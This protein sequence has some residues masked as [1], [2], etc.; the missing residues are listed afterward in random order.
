MRKIKRINHNLAYGKKPQKSQKLN[1]FEMG[2]NANHIISHIKKKKLWL[3]GM[4]LIFLF[5]GTYIQ[6]AT[7]PNSI[8][9][10]TFQKSGKTNLHS[11]KTTNS[12]T[13]IPQPSITEERFPNQH[14][15]LYDPG[16]DKLEG[17][18]EWQK[19]ETEDVDDVGGALTG[20]N[21]SL[22]TEGDSDSYY[23][24]ADPLDPDWIVTENPDFPTF[25][26]NHSTDANGFNISHF[27]YETPDQTPSIHWDYN[28]SLP[29]NL[30][31]YKITDFSLNATVNGSVVGDGDGTNEGIDVAGDGIEQ[32]AT[33]DYARY[34]VLIS[35]IPKEKEYELAFYQTV[36]LGSDADGQTSNLE[37]TF[38]NVL[39]KESLILYLESVLNTD[40]QNFTISL[41]IRL[42]CEDS[43]H[44]DIDTWHYIR[45]NS[46]NMSISWERKINQLSSISWDQTGK[47]I[48]KTY[49][50]ELYPDSTVNIE[51]DNATLD[52]DY[53]IDT[54]WPTSSLNSELKYYIDNY[55]HIE[56]L[57]LQNASLNV[58]SAK[59]TSGY[60]VKSLIPINKNITFEIKLH[61]ADNFELGQIITLTLDNITLNVGYTAVIK[62]PDRDSTFSTVG[63]P[64]TSIIWNETFSIDFNY[65][66]SSTGEGIESAEVDVIWVDDYIIEELTGAN[67]GIYRIMANTSA[68]LAPDIYTLQV[69]IKGTYYDQQTLQLGINIIGRQ[70]ITSVFLNMQNVTESPV[71][72]V[73]IKN[74]VNLTGI[75]AE[76]GTNEPLID[77][78]VSLIG[79]SIDEEDYEYSESENQYEFLINSTGLGLGTHLISFYANYQNY[80]QGYALIRIEVIER[81]SML[82]IYINETQLTGSNK[83]EMEIM[84]TL[85]I[86]VG[87]KDKQTNKYINDASM[88]IN[89]PMEEEAEAIQKG[90][91]FVFNLDSQDFGLGVHFISMIGEHAYYEDSVYTIQLEIEQISTDISTLE[92]NISYVIE[93]ETSIALNLTLRESKSQKVIEDAFVTYSWQY[94]SGEAI[95]KE[96]YYQIP[97]ENV[98]EGSYTVYITVSKGPNYDFDTFEISLVAAYPSDSQ[99]GLPTWALYIFGGTL[100]G[101]AGLFYRYQ[102]VWKYPKVIQKI[103]KVKKSLKKG[104]TNISDFEFSSR[105]ETMAKSF[106]D[107]NKN[108]KS[109]KNFKHIKD[110]YIQSSQLKK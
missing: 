4:G 28:I 84:E 2:K 90:D 61:I 42:W 106:M 110:K 65:T 104:M 27:W 9:N 59:G 82:D 48:N 66:D 76:R 23:F 22:T 58:Q 60:D 45:I 25:P 79:S 108:P 52:F 96:G 94:G 81:T 68:T 7:S 49:Y 14:Q 64:D 20:E 55:E 100:V 51:I 70:T 74:Q 50:E 63:S 109:A 101:L 93:P 5:I 41:G 102:K 38:M 77:A 32:H 97:M 47:M 92:G 31:D 53:A 67:A 56:G 40:H 46:F 69:S 80:Q 13:T 54:L 3:I 85:E 21:A 98:K 88:A 33:Y 39:S 11:E 24:E 36:D 89:S 6:L 10:S 37:D 34:Y 103:H 75:Y 44:T 95:A 29:T 12:Q 91:F 17:T 1:K 78:N 87:M 18:S 16:F 99:G 107:L 8:N 35:D 15:I 86:A 43:W 62:T 72:N 30:S 19:A 73:P 26:D 105:N 71:I 57:N 83:I